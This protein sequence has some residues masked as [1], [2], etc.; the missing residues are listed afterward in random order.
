MAEQVTSDGADVSNDFVPDFFLDHGGAVHLEWTSI[1]FS[2]PAGDNVQM[3]AS[4][5]ASFPNLV[6]TLSSAI[7][8]ADHS[9]QDVAVTVNGRQV[10][11]MVW[12]RIINSRNQVVY[13]VFSR[14]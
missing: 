12:V 7:G 13:R 5:R 2:D 14:L 11:V 8:T 6:R 1:G 3:P 4:D 9:P 10:F